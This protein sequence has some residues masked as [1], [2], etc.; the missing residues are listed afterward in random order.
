MHQ[1]LL[2]GVLLISADLDEILAISDRVVVMYDG[3]LTDVGTVDES[4]REKIGRAMTGTSV[5]GVPRAE[6]QATG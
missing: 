3:R 5:E 2:S 6:A 4:T 1:K